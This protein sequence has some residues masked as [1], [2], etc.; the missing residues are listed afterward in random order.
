MTRSASSGS[1][2]VLSRGVLY[3]HSAPLAVVAHVEWAIARVLG[4]P[5][6]LQWSVQPVDPT[7]RR[8]ECNWSGRPGTGAEFVTAL[9]SWPMLRFEV[10]EEP[11][12]GCDGER[13]MYVPGRGVFRAAMSV[14]G[15]LMLTED[16]VRSVLVTSRG[17]EAMAHA[18]GR[19][20]GSAWDDELEPYRHA[21][22]GAPATRLTQVS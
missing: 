11:S 22:E 12:L 8:M 17:A 13:Y 20:L 18:L 14:T 6:R 16:Q 4:T 2:A 5:V 19:L 1:G 21:G 3:V 15:G 10:T 9:R 7:T